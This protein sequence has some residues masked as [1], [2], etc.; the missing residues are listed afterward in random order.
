MR[1]ATNTASLALK[2]PPISKKPER[3][4][5]T[6]KLKLFF[7]VDNDEPHSGAGGFYA[8]FKFAEFLAQR[9]HT[10][11]IASVHDLGWVKPRPNLKLSFR[12]SLSRKKSLIAKLD[13]FI[14]MLHNRWW[15]PF[16][17]KQFQPDWIVGVL[18]Y[19][20]IDAEKIG[21]K[22]QIPVANFIYECPPWLQEIWGSKYIIE[23]ANPTIIKVWEKTRN[24]YLGSRVLFPNSG[25]S[26]QY[27][28]KWL[29]GR[30]VA[31]PIHPG[32]DPDQMPF[33]PPANEPII[34]D[35]QR[36]H[37]LFVG[38]LVENKKVHDL[39]AA[40]HRLESNAEL[41][42]CGTGPE[43]ERLKTLA[44]G[45]KRIQ[46]HGYVPDTVL[47]S[48][49]RQCTLLVYPTA[50][51][52]FGMPPMQALYFAKP[53]IASDLDIFRSIFGD[54]LEYFT[55][56][57]IA[58]LTTSIDRLLR[59]PEYCRVR[60]EAGRQFILENFTWDIAAQRIEQ[61]LLEANNG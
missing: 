34:L 32:I 26:R 6:T 20:A 43:L 46:F 14:S 24:A 53:C 4:N 5:P 1:G 29:N 56:G 3:I 35:S 57:A 28:S 61:N 33:M 47:W 12:P 16:S 50:F 58:E 41:H 51:E 22:N 13:R 48:L 39:I 9:G 54:H 17:V 40:F 8:I 7:I 15:L 21:Q 25:L 23:N 30:E 31:E 45:S 27:N 11:H 49:F 10:I 2:V 44:Y 38:R 42:I 59:D 37:L 52:G 55:I 36:A 18:T 60:G 19:S